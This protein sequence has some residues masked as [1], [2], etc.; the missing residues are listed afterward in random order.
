MIDGKI[1]KK[2]LV[3]DGAGGAA[4]SLGDWADKPV[5]YG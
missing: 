4:A 5:P 1:V 3:V 2:S